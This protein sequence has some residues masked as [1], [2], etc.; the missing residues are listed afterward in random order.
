MKISNYRIQIKTNTYL[1]GFN[2]FLSKNNYHFENEKDLIKFIEKIYK[3]FEDQQISNISYDF[4]LKRIDINL[5]NDKTKYYKNIIIYLKK[6]NYN[7]FKK[8]S[9]KQKVFKFIYI[10]NKLYG[11]KHKY[12]WIYK[13]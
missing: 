4:D 12:K 9:N 1:N 13:N 10:E 2:S 7:L 11:N 5:F 3:P 8:I 6:D